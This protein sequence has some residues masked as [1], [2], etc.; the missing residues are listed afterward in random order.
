MIH[1][2]KASQM[3][4]EPG[5]LNA[6]QSALVDE[7]SAQYIRFYDPKESMYDH[8]TALKRYASENDHLYAIIMSSDVARETAVGTVKFTYEPMHERSSIGFLIFPDYRRMGYAT[9]AVELCTKLC[10]ALTPSRMIYGGCHMGNTGSAKVF[11]KASY[12]QVA[13]LPEFIMDGCGN[14]DSHC[15]YVK[16]RGVPTV[17]YDLGTLSDV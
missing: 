14:V 4:S 16:N 12:D 9:K 7:N 6:W 5:F 15:I 13:S 10:F 1:L 11:K 2:V 8:T 3:L 17:S